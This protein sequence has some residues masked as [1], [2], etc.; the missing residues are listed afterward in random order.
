MRTLR[1]LLAFLLPFRWLIA[2]A[3]LLGCVMIASNMLL[4]GMAAYLIAEAALVPLMVMLTL[5]TFIVR[6]VSVTRAGSRYAERLVSHNVTFR[7]LASLRS[8]V[9]S[10]LEPLAPDRSQQAHSGDIHARLLSDIEELQNLYLRA[11]SP[12]IVAL[13][14]SVLT[15]FLFTIFR[16]LLAW[17]AFAFLAA[18][19][20]G[21]PTLVSLL[22][23]N[24]GKRQLSLRAELKTQ[25]VD[26]LQGVQ[27]LL[28]YGQAGAQQ[29]KIAELDA[30][31]A[32][33]QSRMAVISGLQQ[34]L[35]DLM[36]NLALWT[37]VVLAIPLITSQAISA[38]YLGFLALLIL[39]SFEGVLP[40]GQ[41]FQ[42][43]GNSRAAGERL[44]EITDAPPAVA[45]PA[46]PLP[47][48]TGRS[49]AFEHVSFA[50]GSGETEVL[51]D[52]SLRVSAGQ[53]IALVGSSGSGKSTL[54][55]LAVRFWDP[56]LGTVRLDGQDIREYALADVRACISMVDQE[57]YLFNDTLRG[58][59][60]LGKLDAK[61]E[62][63]ESALAQA[64]LGAFV[65]QLPQGLDTW[66]GEQG[67]RL[68]GGERQRLAIARAL[69]KDAPLLILDEITANL[70]PRTE[71]ELLQALDA[72]MRG[73]TTLIIT[74]RLIAMEHMDEIIVLDQGQMCECGTHKQLLANGG[75][76]RALYEAQ[77][78][79][80]ALV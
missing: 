20:V 67:L 58:N 77:R 57:T 55:R 36:A 29:S 28:A 4:L 44:F 9:Y 68:S 41:A 39:A 75:T 11:V 21:V 43:L 5:P 6:L 50:Y 7:L 56:A 32:R 76:Y 25:L 69:L 51:R 63:I 2:L 66:I 46:R 59:L 78:G 53:R 3:V 64:Q 10:R 31:L 52:I 37:I 1:R 15:F 34:A 65:E 45:A 71:Q 62:E 30:R 19:G 18:T 26:G 14:T 23:R 38:V 12:L 42:F 79:I 47:A 70:D 27:D 24:L 13:A 17:V 80:L 33:V 61:P 54:A 40:L 22:A 72:L 49:L 8:H 73:R 48:P 16:P 35:N 74:H 60:L